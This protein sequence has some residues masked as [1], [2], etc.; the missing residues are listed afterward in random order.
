MLF[1]KLTSKNEA[2]KREEHDSGSGEGSIPYQTNEVLPTSLASLGGR[3]CWFDLCKSRQ[4]SFL[5]PSTNFVY[6]ALA[7]S[8]SFSPSRN[9]WVRLFFPCYHTVLADWPRRSEHAMQGKR[10]IIPVHA[11]AVLKGVPELWSRI[12][13]KDGERIE[14][15]KDILRKEAVERCRPN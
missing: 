10:K 8:R 14:S 3:F 9:L 15:E 6:Q 13:S 7:V 1:W 12:L 5:S 4:A 11:L 2:G